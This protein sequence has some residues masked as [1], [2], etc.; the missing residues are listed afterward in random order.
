MSVGPLTLFNWSFYGFEQTLSTQEHAGVQ[1]IVP[2]RYWT[3]RAYIAGYSHTILWNVIICS[4]E[5]F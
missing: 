1:M 3:R 5:M 2:S 4:K